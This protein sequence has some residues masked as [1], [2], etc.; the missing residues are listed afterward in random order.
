M[1]ANKLLIPKHGGYRKLKSFQAAQLVFDVTVREEDD[2]GLRG[3]SGQC[4]Q[5]EPSASAYTEIAANAALCRRNNVYLL[6]NTSRI[7]SP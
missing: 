6:P 4:G 5:K 1:T 2:R 7:T 3:Q